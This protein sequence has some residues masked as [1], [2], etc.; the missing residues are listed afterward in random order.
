MF[1][2]LTS[3]SILL[4]VFLFLSCS[5]KQSVK[6]DLN[7]D[8]CI[9]LRKGFDQSSIWHLNIQKL[10]ETDDSTEVI[11]SNFKNVAYRKKMTDSIYNGDWYADSVLI[12]FVNVRKS[13]QS[14]ELI[15]L[16]AD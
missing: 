7:N 8:T 15:Y 4:L 3:I 12:K 10:G 14:I 5:D 16:F 6:F 1:N 11:I 2:K 9:V 13:S